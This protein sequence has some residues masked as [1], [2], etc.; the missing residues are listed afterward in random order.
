MQGRL[1]HTD[2]SRCMCTP[3]SLGRDP[4]QCMCLGSHWI[5]KKAFSRLH[6]GCLGTMN[7]PPSRSS[8][9]LIVGDDGIP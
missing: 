4:A 8:G 6:I 5:I 9:T 3:L 7:L 1:I 2:Q